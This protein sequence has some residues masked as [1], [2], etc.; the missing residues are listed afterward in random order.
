MSEKAFEYLHSVQKA[1]SGSYGWIQW[2]GTNVCIDIHC[3]CGKLSHVDGDFL[4]FFECECGKRYGLSGYVQM[5]E[6]PPEYDDVEGTGVGYIKSD[7]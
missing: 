7:E 1:P 6:I 3:F 4:Y 5:T 2:K